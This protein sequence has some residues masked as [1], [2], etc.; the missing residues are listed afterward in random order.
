MNDACIPG[1]RR[2]AEAVH[3]EGAAIIG[4]IFHGGREIMDSDDGTLPVPLGPSAVPNERFH[5]MPRAMSVA[6]IG[7]IE[8]GFADAARRL[9]T[10]GLDGVEIVASHG[11][12]PSQFLSP[13]VNLRTDEYGGSPENR[14]RF[15][16]EILAKVRAAMDPGAVVGL[17]ISIDE[18]SSGRA[19][20]RRVA[21]RAGADRPRRAARTMSAWSPGPPRRWPAP[22]TSSRR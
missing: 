8:A 2:L 17:R 3:A 4:Q 9:R 20:P 18:R 15:L 12:L 6:E 11:Y 21:G 1:F 22:T 14:A 13:R 16:R 10:A 5:V 19:D 7:M